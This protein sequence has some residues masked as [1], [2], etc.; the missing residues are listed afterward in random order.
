[1]D[2]LAEQITVPWMFDHLDPLAIK[3][4]NGKRVI[5]LVPSDPMPMKQLAGVKVL[6]EKCQTWQE[7]QR[8]VSDVVLA[9]PGNDLVVITNSAVVLSDAFACQIYTWRHDEH[10]GVRY[11]YVGSLS[12]FGAS[13]DR[14]ALH[15]FR[16][17]ETI[18]NLCDRKLD[19][20][21]NT[22]WTIDRI[23]ELREICDGIGGGWPRAK[24]Q[25][26]LDKLE[27]TVVP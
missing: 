24:L 4:F 15:V 23:G 6:I 14:I 12:T 5:F 2:E 1:M 25:E 17:N 26:S 21:L 27:A 13:P 9:Q 16:L 22:E 8:F 7:Q 20:W 11:R 18:G 10:G 19:E 3:V